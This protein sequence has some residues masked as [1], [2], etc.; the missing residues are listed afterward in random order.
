MLIANMMPK[1]ALNQMANRGDESISPLS[2]HS[3]SSSSSNLSYQKQR[4]QESGPNNNTNNSGGEGFSNG[5]YYY[6][7]YKNHEDNNGGVGGGGGSGGG[8]GGSSRIIYKTTGANASNGNSIR[9]LKKAYNSKYDEESSSVGM[10]S[11]KNILENSNRVITSADH[12][13]S[14]RQKLL[15]DDRQQMEEKLL[16]EN[17]GNKDKKSP[18]DDA[19]NNANNKKNEN[20][21][22]KLTEVNANDLMRNDLKNLPGDK[23][24]Q[25]LDDM[26]FNE[27]SLNQLLDD[28]ITDERESSRFSKWFSVSKDDAKD[29][30]LPDSQNNNGGGKKSAVTTGAFP[31]ETEKYFQPIDKVDNNNSL[32]QVLKAQ[33][34]SKGSNSGSD[35]HRNNDPLLNMLQQHHH[36]QQQQKSSPLSPNSGQVH[37]LEE[38]EAKLRH[39]KLNQEDH[40]RKTSENEKKVLQNFFQQQLMPNLMQQSPQ[41]Q[42]HHQ[43]QAPPQQQQQPHMNQQNQEDINAFKKLLSQIANDDG[44]SSKIPPQMLAAQQN[45]QNI[46]QQLMNKGVQPQHNNPDMMQFQKSF[47]MAGKMPPPTAKMMNAPHMMNSQQQP[48]PFGSGNMDMKFL[49]QQQKLPVPEI[50]K[51]PE[52]NALVQ[53][54]ILLLRFYLII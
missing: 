53:G 46:L 13:G 32:F 47:P 38:L 52:V 28:K 39:H 36:Q 22:T 42:Q 5:R 25:Q 16:A 33:D 1:F 27:M 2:F 44:N 18:S 11:N 29:E 43:Q 9:F 30:K 20:D 41:Q 19:N 54:K 34:P 7:K 3:N 10:I 40:D 15:D 26:I 23:F 45:G 12:R 21:S 48:P 35:M 51:R 4:Y 14:I 24:D 50:V 8:S 31:H 6:N 49:Q 17:G 37:S